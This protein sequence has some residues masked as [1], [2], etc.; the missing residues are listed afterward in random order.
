LGQAAQL[1]CSHVISFNPPLVVSVCLQVVFVAAAYSPAKHQAALK[2]LGLAVTAGAMQQ[3]QQSSP[4]AFV[5]AADAVKQAEE[6]Q[7][8]QQSCLQILCQQVHAA[9]LQLL[10][11]GP[12]LKQQEQQQGL[13]VILDSLPCVSA[14]SQG[15]ARQVQALIHNLA[16]LGEQLQ[17]GH[18]PHATAQHPSCIALC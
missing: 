14:L 13:L 9:A 2:K 10:G 6:Q 8:Q 12:D 5:S 1:S 4:L 11:L 7:Q 15:D 17:V 18:P 3:Q 16:A